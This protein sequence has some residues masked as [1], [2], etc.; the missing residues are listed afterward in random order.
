MYE[1]G[2]K[3]KG[4]MNYIWQWTKCQPGTVWMKMYLSHILGDKDPL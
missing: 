4:S 2:N 3:E 1:Q